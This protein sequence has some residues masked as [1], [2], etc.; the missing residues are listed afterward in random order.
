MQ[1]FD[2]DLKPLWQTEVCTV[3]VG[4]RPFKIAALQNGDFVVAGYKDFKL[5]LGRVSM[6]NKDVKHVVLN[7]STVFREAFDLAA[8]DGKLYV[9]TYVGALDELQ[10]PTY[11]L[12]LVA[13]QSE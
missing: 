12:V 6:K 13:I 10:K 4:V 11:K 2:T 1:V 7:T 5:W 8:A 9:L 3:D